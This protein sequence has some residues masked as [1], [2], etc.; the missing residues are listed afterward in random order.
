MLETSIDSGMLS[1]PSG[2]MGSERP[3]REGMGLRIFKDIFR[4]LVLTYYARAHGE[5]HSVSKG[6][7][8]MSQSK[9]TSSKSQTSL[10]R[11]GLSQDDK[12]QREDDEDNERGPPRKRAKPFDPLNPEKP[13]FLACPFWKLNPR[14]HCSCFFKK[15]T[16]IAYVKQHLT[17]RHTSGLYC[18]RCFMIFENEHNLDRHVTGVPCV[19]DP[20]ARLQ[21]VSQRQSLRL[22]AKSKGTVEDQWYAMW[23]ILFPTD[24]RP[25]S[26]RVDADG[27]QDLALFREFSQKHGLVVML[28]E[29]RSR[30]LLPTLGTS[31]A[32]LE[33][34]LSRGLD[35]LFEHYRLNEP[36]PTSSDSQSSS[37][38]TRNHSH[39]S[40]R[41]D[42]QDDSQDSG[43]QM[44]LQP[45]LHQSSLSSRQEYDIY[46][47]QMPS[48]NAI[49]AQSSHEMSQSV[50]QLTEQENSS[51]PWLLSDEPSM[52]LPELPW[53]PWQGT[54]IA[55][56]SPNLDALL[57]NFTE[58]EDE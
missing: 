36:P 56:A 26:I 46:G 43:V 16:K 42:L 4:R 35:A 54:Q 12:R 13:K 50:D 33:T 53:E 15:M 34:I 18:Q 2:S 22:S 37:N 41:L 38:G 10:G 21:V 32:E 7:S 5:A 31:Y 29:F 47:S 28:E 58:L 3:E 1:V 6:P 30:N 23:H 11:S 14:E 25:S 55:P 44:S 48:N 17:R 27:P 49:S 39:Q 24:P 45:S 57:E 40:T 19:R 52:H 8:S 9:Q 20:S 51:D